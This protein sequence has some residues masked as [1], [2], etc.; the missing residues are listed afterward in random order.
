MLKRF[1]Q[2]RLQAKLLQLTATGD[3]E[4]WPKVRDELLPELLTNSLDGGASVLERCIGGGHHKLLGEI[5]HRFPQLTNAELSSGDTLPSLAIN[6]DQAVA[7]LSALL[8]NGLDPNSQI[9]DRSLLETVLEQPPARAM[10]LVNR[11]VQHGATLTNPSLLRM[12]IEAGDTALIKFMVDSGAPLDPLS[13][14]NLNP[15][16]VAFAQRAIEDK[17]IRDMWA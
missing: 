15:E 2:S 4:L 13:V 10:L 1:K 11:L 7:L 12:A 6:A 9:N 16:L 14:N 5:L 17:K 8:L 3:L